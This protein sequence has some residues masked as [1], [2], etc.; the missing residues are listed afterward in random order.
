MQRSF[1]SIFPTLHTPYR[2][3]NDHKV[4][5]GNLQIELKIKHGR[6]YDH[7][8]DFPLD[9]FLSPSIRPVSLTKCR[10]MGIH[11]SGVVAC[12]A[13]VPAAFAFSLR[14]LLPLP[15]QLILWHIATTGFA[16]SLAA[17][18]PLASRTTWLL[19]KKRDGSI[20]PISFVL[21]WPYHVALRTKLALQRRF[22]KEAPWNKVTTTYYI[23]S[24]PAAQHLLPNKS[25]AVIDVT[26]ELPLMVDATAYKLIPV[27]DTHGK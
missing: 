1:G 7:G 27:W 11:L 19:G 8:A 4:L 14:K 24:W 25:I 17:S 22:S 2:F 3:H 12:A 13:C 10:D 21:F 20:S 15:A 23:G 5:L 9:K 16:V 26:C 6:T 18:V